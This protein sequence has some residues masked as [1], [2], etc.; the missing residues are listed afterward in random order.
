MLAINPFSFPSKTIHVL[1][2][3]ERLI[4][5]FNACW[6]MYAAMPAVLKEAIE[7]AY[8]SAGW[9]LEYSINKYDNELFPDFNDVLREIKTVID[10][11]EYSADNKGDYTGA[12]VTRIRALT[13]G[14]NGQI[15]KSDSLYDSAIFDQNIIIDLSRVGSMETKSLIMGLLI[16]KLQEYRMDAGERNVKLKHI[17]VLEEAHN[18]LR[19]TSVEQ[20]SEGANLR[21]QK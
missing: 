15:F 16:L 9:D 17:T 19:K 5:I 14:I 21:L 13:N 4:E 2:H 3:M 6:P 7:R 8:I 12:L 20:I 1:E 10:R 11:S 18:L